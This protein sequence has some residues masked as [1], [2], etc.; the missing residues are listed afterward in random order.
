MSFLA[1]RILVFV[2][3]HGFAEKTLGQSTRQTCRLLSGLSNEEGYF[4]A[5]VFT[6]A[7]RSHKSNILIGMLCSPT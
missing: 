4:S 1:L 5:L 6:R 3:L 2:R 7:S